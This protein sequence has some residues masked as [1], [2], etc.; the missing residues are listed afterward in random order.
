MLENKKSLGLY[1]SSLEG[2]AARLAAVIFTENVRL[3]SM[4]MI[5]DIGV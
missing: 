3:I 5:V 4:Y 2:D 1:L